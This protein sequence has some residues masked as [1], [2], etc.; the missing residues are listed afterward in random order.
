MIVLT[1]NMKLFICSCLLLFM[2]TLYAAPQL[3]P[4]SP[5]VK[6]K[7]YLLVD[8]NSG[9]ILA[10]KRAGERVEPASL[11]KM[12]SAYVVEYSLKAGYI[13]LDDMVLISKKAWKMGGSKMFVEVGK[14]VSVENLLKGVIIQSGN[15]ATIAL[16]EH[17]AGTE[18]EFVSLM[19]Q[20]AERL[21]M[22]GSHFANSTGLPHKDHFSTAHDLVT[23][24]KAIINDFP[25][26]YSWYSIKEFK[27]GKI[28]QPN[29]NRLL[30]RDDG[31]DGIKTGHTNAAGYCLVA[32]AKREDMRL[33]SVLL[34]AKS[35]GARASESHKLLNYGFRY[36]ETKRLYGAGESLTEAQIWKGAKDKVS[37]GIENDLWVTF[38]KG[39]SE[40]LK[41]RYDLIEQIT[42]P[43]RSGQQLGTMT[44]TLGEHEFAQ[45]QVIALE[46][47][48]SG[49][50][51]NNLIDE[52][53]L[54]LN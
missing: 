26:H 52:V 38:P 28:K 11:T 36:F 35:E 48:E 31:I 7:A 49:G 25:K 42:A 13:A 44:I 37:I 30:W 54:L 12:M 2:Q 8:F 50:L 4:S 41:T 1:R 47:V 33:I 29:R 34:G 17:I 40:K 32:S 53:K 5:K 18:K 19:N 6:A 22:F 45:R 23:L 20:H 10:E 24:A 46:E 9:K 15:D 21:G 3:L 16:A 51:I 14:K 27:W 43:T 39:Q